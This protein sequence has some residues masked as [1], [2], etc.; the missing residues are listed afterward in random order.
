MVENLD[1]ISSNVLWNYKAL[2]LGLKLW[3]DIVDLGDG[4]VFGGFDEYWVI[5]WLLLL[6]EL[7]LLEL[8]F[9]SSIGTW[10]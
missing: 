4:A 7:L 9:Y 10:G 5:N 8:L 6:L 3:A 2:E 1:L